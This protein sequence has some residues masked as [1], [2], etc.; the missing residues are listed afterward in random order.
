MDEYRR[1]KRSQGGGR[2]LVALIDELMGSSDELE[3]IH[4]V[5]FRGYFIPKQPS[6]AARRDCP[7][8]YVFWVAPH[9]I[10][11]SALVGDLL[12]ASYDADL[13]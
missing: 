2:Y 13:V 7:G 4:V 3:A 9:Q 11:E 1:G 10:A 8:A 12:R 6:C 5:E